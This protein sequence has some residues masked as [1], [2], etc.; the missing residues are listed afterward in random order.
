MNNDEQITDTELQSMAQRADA[1]TR[2]AKAM[3]VLRRGP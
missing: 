1:A 3:A 2:R